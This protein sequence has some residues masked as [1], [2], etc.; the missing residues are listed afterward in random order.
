MSNDALETVVVRN[1]FY[2]DGYRKSLVIILVL[3]VTNLLALFSVIRLYNRPDPV[4]FFATTSDGRIIPILPLDQPGKRDAEIIDWAT[5]AAIKTYTYDFVNYRDALQQVS[6]SFTG[7]GWTNFQR[8][9]QDSGMLKTVIA[10]QL[11]MTAE[12]TM[13]AVIS[14]KGVSRTGRYTW[15]IEIPMLLKLKGPKS[16]TVPVRVSMLLQRVSLVNN[17]DGIAIVN[18]VVSEA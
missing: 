7:N 18:Y 1:E 10:Q 3:V 6:Q 9:M 14:D 8:A 16:M 2:R 17:P 11:V 12:P 5:K 13:A 15:K 4:A